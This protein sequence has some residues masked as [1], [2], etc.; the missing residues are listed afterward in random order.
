MLTK[1]TREIQSLGK[2]LENVND[3]PRAENSSHVLSSSK[4]LKEENPC[5]K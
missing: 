1:G 3:C 2:V 4:D 5:N